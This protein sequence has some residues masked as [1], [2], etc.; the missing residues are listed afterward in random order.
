M[1]EHQTFNLLVASSNLAILRMLKIVFNTNNDFIIQKLAFDKR[2]LISMLVLKLKS[3]KPGLLFMLDVNYYRKIFKNINHYRRGYLF[4]IHKKQKK[5]YSFR[6]RT[7]LHHITEKLLIDQKIIIKKVLTKIYEKEN[8]YKI[9]KERFPKWITADR[10]YDRAKNKHYVKYVYLINELKKF[11]EKNNYHSLVVERI[12]IFSGKLITQYIKDYK[13]GNT[14][15]SNVNNR[16]ININFLR[17]ERLY[18]KL[19]YSRSPAYD[20]VSGGSAA[21]LA[22]FLGFLISEKYGFE[23][24]D[25]GDFYYLFMYAVFFALT[26]KSWS[27]TLNYDM[28]WVEAISYK[29]STWIFTWFMHFRLK[30]LKL[31]VLA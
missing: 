22:A 31:N 28:S 6:L 13:K 16:L 4:K 19:K 26:F 18:T 2:Y 14:L 9:T 3:L 21:L 29:S 8:I 24:V 27:G 17:K 1:V 11:K 5:D 23:L 30:F 7:N 10:K 12:F 25:S 15:H 20:I